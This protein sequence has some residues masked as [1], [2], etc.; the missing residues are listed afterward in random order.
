MSDIFIIW[1]WTFLHGLTEIF[2]II[3]SFPLKNTCWRDYVSM[4]QNTAHLPQFFSSIWISQLWK[5]SFLIDTQEVWC[6]TFNN[7]CVVMDGYRRYQGGGQIDLTVVSECLASLLLLWKLRSSTQVP[8]T[9]IASQFF[10]YNCW[11]ISILGLETEAPDSV[12]NSAIH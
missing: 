9:Q 2:L 7:D 5:L 8:M 12:F 3:F 1:S 11:V 4:S 6:L 10:P